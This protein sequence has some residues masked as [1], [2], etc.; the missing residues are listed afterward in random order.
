MSNEK[1]LRF[2]ISMSPT[3]LPG[4]SDWSNGFTLTKELTGDLIGMSEGLFINAGQAEGMRSYIVVE[5]LSGQ[6]PEGEEAGVILEHG[7]IEDDDS[8]WF[9]RIVPGTGIGAW[10]G[11]TGVLRFQSD[12]DGEMMLLTLN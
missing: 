1:I 6:T 2:E 8:A 11:I 3:E 5:K 10:E 7:G 4:I 12:D 9:G